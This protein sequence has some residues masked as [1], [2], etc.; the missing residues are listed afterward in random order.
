[1]ARNGE[2]SLRKS[3]G[4]STTCARIKKPS[5]TNNTLA[6]D[7][8]SSWYSQEGGFHS[9]THSPFFFPQLA[10]ASVLPHN[11]V[12]KASPQIVT[13]ASAGNI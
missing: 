5:W 7:F 13:R 6:A 10:A 8:K 1:M 12:A 11:I 3:I 2:I 4:I 9:H